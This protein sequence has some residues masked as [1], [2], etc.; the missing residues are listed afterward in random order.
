V[1]PFSAPYSITDSPTG[2]YANNSTTSF[3]MNENI[4]LTHASV[5]VLNYSARWSIEAGYDYVQISI[6]TNNGS[7]W[8]PLQGLYTK[9]GSSNQAVG[10][11]LYD[12]IQN[13]WVREEINLSPYAGQEIKLRFRL[14][15]DAGATADGFFFDDLKLTII[16]ISTGLDNP[17][18]LLNDVLKGPWPNPA[19][20]VVDFQYQ[21]PTPGA[22][23]LV[24]DLS[25]R[26]IMRQSLSG[27]SG[28]QSVSTSAL[29][30]GLYLCKI[31]Q[32]NKELSTVKMIKK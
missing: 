23:L 14:R 2:N 20:D 12:G 19:I 10:Q 8:T 31:V 17:S 32:H 11:P 24:T 16:D 21:L 4:D 5:A 3:I 29:A 22:I 18:A 27:V 1:F 9:A 13:A 30:P 28:K 26:E 6:S 15:T 7:T 25:G